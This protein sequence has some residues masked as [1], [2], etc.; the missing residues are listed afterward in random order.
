MTRD[1]IKMPPYLNAAYEGDDLFTG[2]QLRSVVLAERE[3][4]A[5]VCEDIYNDPKDNNGYDA[6][7]TRPY[8]ECAAAIRAR[9]QKT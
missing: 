2:D 1:D 7:Y 6:Y 4:C 9:G 3:A 5:K 8:L